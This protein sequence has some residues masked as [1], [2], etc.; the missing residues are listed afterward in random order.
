[1]TGN[2]KREAIQEDTLSGIHKMSL[3]T[4][5]S[6]QQYVEFA[7]HHLMDLSRQFTTCIY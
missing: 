6:V 2:T 7:M 5:R 3:S 4:T 1:M